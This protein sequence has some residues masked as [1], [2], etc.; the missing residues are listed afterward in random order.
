MDRLVGDP[1]VR[2]VIAAAEQARHDVAAEDDPDRRRALI[3][4]HRD[5]WVAF[6]PHF[7]RVFGEKC[8][9]TECR[10]PGTDDDVDHFRPKGRVAEDGSHGGYWWEALRWRNFRLSCHRANRLRINPDT[11]STQGK[12]D[13]FPLVDATQRWRDPGQPNHERPAL[14]DPVKPGDPGL[15]TFDID[16][17]VALSPRH[18][19][20]PEARRRV[21]VSRACLHLDWPAIRRERQLLYAKVAERVDEGEMAADALARGE[22]S[23][24]DWLDRVAAALI[25]LTDDKQPYSRAAQAY[26]RCFRYLEWVEARVV[27]HVTPTEPAGQGA[28]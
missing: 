22:V 18:C 12:G 9:Y 28:A 15:L 6:R 20:E 11:G 2:K 8:W 19:D 23:A 1:V 21:E 14:L 7:E 27:P 13:H 16:G 3:E 17:R 24:T 4:R 25:E 10:N 26:V 5:K